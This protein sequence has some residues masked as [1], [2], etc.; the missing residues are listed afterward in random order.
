MQRESQQGAERARR[1]RDQS[2]AK[3]ECKEMG[4]V[5]NNEAK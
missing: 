5:R 2:D 3:S 4:G 1:N